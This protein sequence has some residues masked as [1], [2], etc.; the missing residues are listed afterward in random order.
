MIN[1]LNSTYEI[2]EW[3]LMRQTGADNGI[4]VGIARKLLNLL[5]KLQVWATVKRI[6]L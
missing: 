1:A 4:R 6:P 5:M 2:V 3:F